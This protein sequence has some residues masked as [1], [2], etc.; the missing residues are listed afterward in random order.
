MKRFRREKSYSIFCCDAS[1]GSEIVMKNVH[2]GVYWKQYLCE[3]ASTLLTNADICLRSRTSR[4]TWHFFSCHVHRGI[5]LANLRSMNISWTV[6]KPKKWITTFRFEIWRPIK[7]WN[8]ECG[9]S[10]SLCTYL[11]E[12]RRVLIPFITMRFCDGRSKTHRNI[13]WR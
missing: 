5:S 9:F 3:G 13:R 1:F 8:D 11:H 12:I 2:R 6:Q 10:V 7:S 4:V